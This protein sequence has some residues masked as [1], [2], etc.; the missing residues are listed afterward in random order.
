MNDE[1]NTS[2]EIQ[3]KTDTSGN[4]Q[5]A[6]EKEVV[7]Q[8]NARIK[9][10]EL[11]TRVETRQSYS[12]KLL[13]R[14]LE[15]FNEVDRAL[16]TEVVNGTLRW[17]LRL[18]W[19]LSQLYVG[20]YKNLISD[21]KNNLRSSLYQLIYLDKIPAYAVLNEAVEIAKT[22]FNQKTANLV[23]AILRNYLRQ[24]Q[25]LEYLEIQLDILERLAINYSHPS[26]LIQRWIENWGVDEVELL[27]QANNK[28][29]RISIRL[30]RLSAQIDSFFSVLEE[31]SIPYEVHPDFPDFVWIDDFS[32]FRKLDFLKKGWVS[33]Q[34]ISAGLPVLLLDPQKG[35]VILDMCSAPGGKAGYMTEKMENEGLLIALERHYSRAKFLRDNLNRVDAKNFHVITGDSLN[36]P[37]KIQFD[38]IL[39]DAPCSGLGVLNKRV[40]LKWK[41]TQQDIEN[42]SNLQSE[43]LRSAANALKPNGVIVY[44]TCTIEPLENEVVIENFLKNH[45]NFKL[46]NLRQ[47]APQHYLWDKYT[48]RTFPHQHQCD[49]SF[50]VRLL[51]IIEEPHSP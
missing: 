29:P 6:V 10:I 33:V 28:R 41:R 45:P 13:E 47:F 25:K 12:D 22:K 27:C 18:D 44:S 43:M 37:F 20:E 24:A 17:Q 31:N 9:I 36:L 11:L 49:G 1:E 42:M 5:E 38:K 3:E 40:D 34:D 50:A 26:W 51:K 32:E 30:N 39:I 48:L 23:N 21:V 4:D 46:D 14:T 16:V 19:I 35:E 15:E 2:G 7:S 8:L